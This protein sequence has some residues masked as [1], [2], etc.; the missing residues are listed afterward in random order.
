MVLIP[1]RAPSPVGVIED[2]GH[3]G[4]S[5]SRLA[6]L[7]H[8][9]LKIRS[10]NLLQIRDPEHEANRVE[11]VGLAGPVEPRNR[12]E[13]RVEP[14]DHGSRRVG[15]EPFQAYLLDVHCLTKTLESEWEGK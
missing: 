4:L 15:F 9:L 3:S 1:E 5:N 8:E 10:P 2:D 6:L 12:V 14:W 11:D 7:V 13:K